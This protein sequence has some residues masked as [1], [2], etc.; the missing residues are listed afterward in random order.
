MTMILN[1]LRVWMV[2]R[3]MPARLINMVSGIVVKNWN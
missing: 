1:R 3:H 2:R